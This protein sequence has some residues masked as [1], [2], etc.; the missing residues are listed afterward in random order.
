MVD[1]RRYQKCVGRGDD[2][3][4]PGS[5]VVPFG[6]YRCAECHEQYELDGL[7]PERAVRPDE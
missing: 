6:Q 3:R 1:N 4:C 7:I 2:T 5:A